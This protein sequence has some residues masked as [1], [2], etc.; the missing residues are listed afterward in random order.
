MQIPEFTDIGDYVS[1]QVA[2]AISGTQTVEEAL[3]KSQTYTE[4]VVKKA[5]YLK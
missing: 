4:G 3:R 1:Q 5:G 2:S